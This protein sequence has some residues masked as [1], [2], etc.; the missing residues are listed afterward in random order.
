MKNT[1]LYKKISITALAVILFISAYI[2]FQFSSASQ[3]FLHP[4]ENFGVN[5][6]QSTR[7]LETQKEQT[8]DSVPLNPAVLNLLLLDEEDSEKDESIPIT[9]DTPVGFVDANDLIPSDSGTSITLVTDPDAVRNHSFTPAIRFETFFTHATTLEDAV[10]SV[11]LPEDIITIEYLTINGREYVY[12]SAIDPWDETYYVYKTFIEEGAIL[13]IITGDEEFV[14]S[15]TLREV[16]E[17]IDYS[18]G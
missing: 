10:N 12:L 5:E 3:E 16:V 14:T 1:I 2:Y 6:G 8:Q 9:F 15:G 17:S 18:G 7:S 11:T 13:N 4:V